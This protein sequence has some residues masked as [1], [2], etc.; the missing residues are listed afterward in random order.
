VG[1][2]YFGPFKLLAGSDM[3]ISGNHEN[4]DASFFTF[5]DSLGGLVSKAEVIVFHKF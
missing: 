3:V 5:T 4:F 2:L 1:F